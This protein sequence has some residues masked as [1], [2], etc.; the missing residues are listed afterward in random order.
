M[1]AIYPI[2]VKL[3]SPLAKQTGVKE[4]L[5]PA[6]ESGLFGIAPIAGSLRHAN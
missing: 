4:S 5:G 2:R 3:A 1:A 6:I